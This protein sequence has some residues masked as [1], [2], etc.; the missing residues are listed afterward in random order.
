MQSIN[1]VLKDFVPLKDA[2]S[3]MGLSYS[4]ILSYVRKGVFPSAV[5]I[6]GTRWHIHNRDIENFLLGKISIKGTFKS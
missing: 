4:Q 1:L 3:R 2:A 5:K 6:R